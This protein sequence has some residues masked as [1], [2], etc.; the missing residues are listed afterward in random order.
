MA[1]KNTMIPIRCFVYTILLLVSCNVDSSGDDTSLK[2]TRE[3]VE[4]VPIHS[5]RYTQE[6]ISSTFTS[7]G[8]NIKTVSDKINRKE[9]SAEDFKR[10]K[11]IKATPSPKTSGEPVYYSLDNR[12]L[13]A[14]KNSRLAN[15]SIAVTIADP[16]TLKQN[17]YKLTSQND[18]FSIRITSTGEKNL[19]PPEWS[20]LARIKQ[21]ILSMKCH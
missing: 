10:L 8:T 1:F 9:L 16:N 14:L 5:I 6:T 20:L 18:G 17:V 12:T 19:E 11:V 3:R 15:E 4:I 13:Y 7:T 21:Q 2:A